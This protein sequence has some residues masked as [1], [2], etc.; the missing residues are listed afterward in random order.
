MTLPPTAEHQRAADPTSGP[1]AWKQWG[2]YLAQRAW[3]TVR[4][5]YSE[6]GDAWNSFPHEHS[7]S[8]AYRWNEEGLCGFSDDHQFLCVALSFWNGRDPILK[9]NFFGL[10][11]EQG[12]HGEDVKEYW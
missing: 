8:R 9:E 11:N 6:D 12:N 3:G 1:G 4:E 7:R 2:P 5:D 10:T